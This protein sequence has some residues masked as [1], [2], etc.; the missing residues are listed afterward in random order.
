MSVVLKVVQNT[1]CTLAGLLYLGSPTTSFAGYRLR[2]TGL[3]ASEEILTKVEE[4]VLELQF[5]ESAARSVSAFAAEFPLNSFKQRLVQ[6]RQSQR[7]VAD[8]ERAIAG[9][10]CTLISNKI[11]RCHP[12]D[13]TG[14]FDLERIVSKRRALCFGYSELYYVMANAIDLESSI[15]LVLQQ[16]KE[17]VNE[18][19][20]S[21]QSIIF[22]HACAMTSLSDG[23]VTFVDLMIGK[24]TEPVRYSDTYSKV[25]V[26]D[27]INQ[28][29]QVRLLPRK[30]RVFNL[31][32]TRSYIHSS[33]SVQMMIDEDYKNAKSELDLAVALDPESAT[34]LC[35]RGCACIELKRYARAHQDFNRA[36]ELDPGDFL[37]LFN[38]GRLNIVT[39]KAKEA[40]EDNE[41]V[42]KMA[43]NVAQAALHL[44]ISYAGVGNREA[45]FR[46]L[47]RAA[48]LD[49]GLATQV[50]A[51]RQKIEQAK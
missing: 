11:Q 25:G 32:Q 43:P 30:I 10:L 16:P 34:A 12:D 13:P 47:N 7:L 23:R 27:Y 39:N 2:P 14:Y 31:D 42:V 41:K 48:E 29:S 35:N 24:T 33:R 46:E 45:A 19:P 44:G 17:V 1:L 18:T 4:R 40:V 22:K 38:R 37:P 8:V 21:S 9:E 3:Q 26:I 51:I 28:S 5:S 49:P 50:Q 36:I 20:K 15:V 6:A